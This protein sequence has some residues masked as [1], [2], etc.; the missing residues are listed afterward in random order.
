MSGYKRTSKDGKFSVAWQPDDSQ[1]ALDA[2]VAVDGTGVSDESDLPENGL[3]D[4]DD[5][6]DVQQAVRDE[7]QRLTTDGG[8]E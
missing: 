1:A 7:H 8:T 6:P 2:L 4:L 5:Q 3:V